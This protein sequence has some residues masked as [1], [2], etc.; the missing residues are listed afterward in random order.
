MH[1]NPVHIEKSKQKNKY[2][3]YVEHLMIDDIMWMSNSD[4]EYDDIERA[5][6]YAKG[7]CYIGGMGLGTI[8]EECLKNQDISHIVAVEIDKRVIDVITDRFNLYQV[9]EAHW[10]HKTLDVY[11]GDATKDFFDQKYDFMYWDIWL[12]LNKKARVIMDQC[13]D[14]G[15]PFLKEGG[16]LEAWAMPTLMDQRFLDDPASWALERIKYYDETRKTT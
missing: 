15:K 14:A 12:D 16:V 7:N 6:K 4:D 5:L 8:V 1:L 2:N 9:N 13:F 11:L 10:T 3:K